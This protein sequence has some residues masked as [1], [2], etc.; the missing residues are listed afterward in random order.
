M[1]ISEDDQLAD[2]NENDVVRIRPFTLVPYYSNEFLT[3]CLFVSF[4]RT[5]MEILAYHRQNLGKDLLEGRNKNGKRLK[6]V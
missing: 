1:Q 5:L 3:P 2:E 6:E 4:F